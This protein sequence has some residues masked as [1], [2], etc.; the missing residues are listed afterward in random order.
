LKV[1]LLAITPN[2][3]RLIA[4]AYGIGTGKD[5]IP[6]ENIQKHI[7]HGSVLEHAQFTVLIEGISRSS[8]A[9]LTR[10]RIGCSYSVRSMRYCREDNA[11]IVVPAD[12]A[13]DNSLRGRYLATAEMCRRAYKQL[14]EQGVR[15][16]D[17][18]FILPIA[19]ETKLIMSMNFRSA[20]HFIELRGD[21]AA[22][23]EIRELA[24]RIRDILVREAPHVFGDLA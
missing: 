6:L 13:E 23:W 19:T 1:E 8:L 4:R 7:R 5:E 2:A 11:A 10:H 18:R 9:Q 24:G 3:E 14:V 12:V 17:A 16:Q 22:Q 15:P 20:R 21:K